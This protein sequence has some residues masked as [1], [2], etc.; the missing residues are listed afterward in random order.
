[1]SL[2]AGG[3]GCRDLLLPLVVVGAGVQAGIGVSGGASIGGL[4]GPVLASVA[5]PWLV[6]EL[7]VVVLVVVPLA[8]PSLLRVSGPAWAASQPQHSHEPRTASLNS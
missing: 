6:P 4:S 3:S 1:M 8:R 7:A 5:G 2:V